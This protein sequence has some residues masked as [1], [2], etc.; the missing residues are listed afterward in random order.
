MRTQK[1][2]TLIELMITVAI[3]GILAGIALPAY[4]D[5]VR[6]AKIAEATSGLA[7]MTLKMEQYFQDNR[8]YVGACVGGTIAPLPT[9]NN[10]TF[11]CPTLT[12]TAYTVTATGIAGTNMSAFSYSINQDHA[13]VTL[14]LPAGW[15]LPNPSTCWV[16]SK[17]GSC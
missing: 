15:T 5:Y 11:A 3:I 14:S 12:A 16:R 17:D 10:F 9:A 8:T 2:F 6:R 13:R 1:G 4:M 7:M